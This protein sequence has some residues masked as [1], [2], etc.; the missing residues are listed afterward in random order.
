MARL[1]GTGLG[2]GMAMGT[3]AVVGMRGGM[4][5][6][7]AIPQRLAAQI[8]QHRLTETPE[9]I[10]VAEDYRTALAMASVISWAKVVGIASERA[11]MDAAVPPFPAVTGISG[12]MNS[13]ADDVLVLIDATR[14]VA[15]I[16]PD[17]IYLAQYTA[18]H[19]RVAPKNRIYLDEAH[20]PA[21]TQ[22]GRTILVAATTEGSSVEEA[23]AS[24]P[25]A[26]YHVLPLFFDA[27]DVRK[28][29]NG[30]V[31]TAA[32]KP[33]IVR[34]NPSL[35]IMPLVEAAEYADLT[36]AVGPAADEGWPEPDAVAELLAEIERAQLECAEQDV[37]CAAPRI[38]AEI[39][40]DCAGP[41]ND[42]VRAEEALLFDNHIRQ[43][44]EALAAQGVTRLIAHYDSLNSETLA[45]LSILCAHASVNLLPVMA[46]VILQENAVPP[47]SMP[48]TISPLEVGDRG[49]KP[50]ADDAP[51]TM[52]PPELGG[53]G[54]KS[55]A[56]DSPALSSTQAQ[57]ADHEVPLLLGCGIRGFLASERYTQQ[58]KDAV[59]STTLA[60]CADELNR[61]LTSPTEQAAT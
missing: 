25:D 11:D 42:L 36:F 38:A 28:H 44:L 6:A 35:P 60:E 27:D 40:L 61:M 22:D 31:S 32:G 8:A 15:L 19:D 47:S 4:P 17:P 34:Y 23:L 49:A 56:E 3:A 14:G 30:V 41:M 33:L 52:S 59:R 46:S 12:L 45:Q 26:I 2:A 58:I 51:P 57:T 54:A 43:K 21:S 20:L 39:V 1:R 48:L 10:V 18:E 37:L 16:D 53:R 55:C 5:I 50:S 24:G 29:L 9:V 7:P 13:T